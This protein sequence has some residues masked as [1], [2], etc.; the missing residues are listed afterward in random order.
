MASGSAGRTT[1][2]GRS[3]DRD[4]SA[5]AGTILFGG[6]IMIVAGAFHIIQALVALF[7][8][9]F[10]VAGQEYIYKFDLTSWG[11]IH[12]LGGVLLVLGGIFLFRGAVWARILAVVLASLS[13]ILTSCG[14]RTTRCGAPSSSCSTWSSSGPSWPTP[15]TCD[16]PRSPETA[17]LASRRGH[18]AGLRSTT[19]GSPDGRGWPPT[20]RTGSETG[21]A[22]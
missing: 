4:Y 17:G 10:Y 20:E 5:A 12:L 11:W 8:D 13:A 21:P 7:N 15:A 3:I 6:I 2:P 14:C 19:E 18:F 9:E 22:R 16:T 1:D